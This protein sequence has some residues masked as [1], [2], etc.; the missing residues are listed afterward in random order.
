MYRFMVLTDPDTAAGFRMA[1]VETL[2]ATSPDEVKG[3][4]AS[5]IQDGETGIIAVNEDF[6]QGI[7]ERLMTRIERSS[8]PIVI[9]IPGRS[10]RGG[11]MAY[12][13]RL[14]RRAIGYNV[15]LRR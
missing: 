6:M 8:R 14:L 10:R 7:D 9:P 15:V 4:L 12:I 2:E 1:G 11:G 13:E 3:L 5:L